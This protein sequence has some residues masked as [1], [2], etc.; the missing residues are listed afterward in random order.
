MRHGALLVL[1]WLISSCAPKATWGGRST[2]RDRES[3]YAASARWL[4]AN[5]RPSLWTRNPTA[6]CLIVGW[7][8]Q[9]VMRSANRFARY[10]PTPSLI[11]RLGDVRPPVIPI[12]KCGWDEALHEVVLKSGEKAVSLG[13]SHPEWS[14]PNLAHVV[15]TFRE[16]AQLQLQYECSL[17]RTP[18][19][20]RLRKCV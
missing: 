6:I 18:E 11:N 4:V 7:N 8:D 5:Y 20:W 9:R 12:S 10:D 14:T 16:T 17:T 2:E 15:V 3:I 1:A 19:G 13:I